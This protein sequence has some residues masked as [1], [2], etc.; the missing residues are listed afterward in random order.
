MVPAIVDTD[1]ALRWVGTTGFVTNTSGFFDNGVYLPNGSQLYRIELDGTFI[2]IGDY[3]D[4]GVTYFH[5]NIDAGKVGVIL[6]ANT[7]S[8]FESFV[9]EVDAHSGAVLKTWNLAD[10]ISAAMRAG[11]DDPNQ[12]VYPAPNDWFHLNAVAYNRADDSL[13]VSSREDFLICLDYDT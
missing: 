2:S 6:E 9:L 1:G 4:I 7:A 13:I 11:G 10:I 12:F 8:Y 3:A 5:H